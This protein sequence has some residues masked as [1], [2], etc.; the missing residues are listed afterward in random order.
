MIST[1]RHCPLLRSML[2]IYTEAGKH[3]RPVKVLWGSRD[4]IVPLSCAH[5]LCTVMPKAELIIFEDAGH[6]AFADN[7]D[8]AAAA[9]LGM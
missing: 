4:V 1:M 3:P 6:G 8:R 5:R 7:E 2:P 9:L